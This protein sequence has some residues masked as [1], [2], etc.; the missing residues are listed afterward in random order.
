M[1]YTRD[2]GTLEKWI[3]TQ[4]RLLNGRVPLYCG[5]GGYMLSNP[6]Q[7]NEQIE[8]ARRSRANGF[9]VFAYND[10]FRRQLLPGIRF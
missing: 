3:Q 5:L 7:L 4:Q 8:V 2:S 1:N 9:V 6:Y 10:Q